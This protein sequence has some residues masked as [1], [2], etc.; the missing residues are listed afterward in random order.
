MKTIEQYEIDLKNMQTLSTKHQSKQ[1]LEDIFNDHLMLSYRFLNLE[2][3][4]IPKPPTNNIDLQTN[5]VIMTELEDLRHKLEIQRVESNN[6]TSILTQRLKELTIEIVSL[7]MKNRIIL[8]EKLALQKSIK[9]QNSRPGYVGRRSVDVP[10]NMLDRILELEN[11]YKSLRGE[12]KFFKECSIRDKQKHS[13][14]LDLL[15]AV[16]YSSFLG[17]DEA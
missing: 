2:E 5:N 12:N 11:Q 17:L 7:K 16:I 4:S 15:Y 3:S 6:E 10:H 9:E 14:Q 13:E 8:E 1:K